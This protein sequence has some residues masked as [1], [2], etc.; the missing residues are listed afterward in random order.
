[1]GVRNHYYFQKTLCRL[2]LTR[3]FQINHIMFQWGQVTEADPELLSKYIKM[4]QGI[5]VSLVTFSDAGEGFVKGC[6]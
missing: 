5:F 1:M 6:D 3:C 2:S 4:F